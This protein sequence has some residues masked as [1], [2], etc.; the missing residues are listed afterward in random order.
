M[1]RGLDVGAASIGFSLGEL[2]TAGAS[3]ALSFAAPGFTR[4][5]AQSAAINREELI[6]IADDHRSKTLVAFITTGE[7]LHLSYDV[8]VNLPARCVAAC[9]AH[10]SRIARQ[11]C[12]RDFCEYAC[13]NR[14]E[15]LV[16]ADHRPWICADASTP[17]LPPGS[18]LS[19][20]YDAVADLRP[21]LV[22]M[23]VASGLGESCGRFIHPAGFIPI[24]R[25]PTLDCA[26]A[27]PRPCMPSRVRCLTPINPAL[28]TCCSLELNDG[29]DCYHDEGW[30]S[31]VTCCDGMPCREFHGEI[32]SS[33]NCLEV[34]DAI[35]RVPRPDAGQE[36]ATHVPTLPRGGYACG[37]LPV[38]TVIWLCG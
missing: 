18:G 3:A 30:K 13:L 32:V 34:L 8:A 27:E 25:W 29:Q 38:C 2:V 21:P 33:Y 9:E 6:P 31:V 12:Y 11:S 26:D 28:P 15:L 20:Q 16:N 37:S 17:C 5:G 35:G 7:V 23:C 22:R 19:V 10:Y 36:S 1:Q 24:T 14:S 4:F